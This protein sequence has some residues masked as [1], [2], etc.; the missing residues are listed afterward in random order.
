MYILKQY[1]LRFAIY[2]ALKYLKSLNKLLVLLC[3]RFNQFSVM[4]QAVCLFC[5]ND[6]C[7]DLKIQNYSCLQTLK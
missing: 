1:G 7:C 4:S 6:H 3:N 2:Q 5:V